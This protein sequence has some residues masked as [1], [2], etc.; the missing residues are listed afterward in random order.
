MFHL[1]CPQCQHDIRYDGRGRGYFVKNNSL[2]VDILL[3]YQ[4]IS[5]M[6]RGT[7]VTGFTE[8]IQS[9]IELYIAALASTIFVVM[10]CLTWL[11]LF[12]VRT[13]LFAK[14]LYQLRILTSPNQLIFR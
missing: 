11:L 14:V 8:A 12:L 13:L 4:L 1:Q 6:S 10:S 7:S 2:V 5:P 3:L 9:P